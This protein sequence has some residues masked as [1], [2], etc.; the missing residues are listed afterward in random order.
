[1]GKVTSE[2]FAELLLRSA[3][4]AAEVAQGE[5]EPARTSRH[6]ITSRE[7]AVRQPPRFGAER[8]VGLREKLGVSQTVFAGM[9]GVQP[10]TV[11]AWEQEQ[12]EPA[13]AARRLLEI[14]EQR[15]AL[16]RATLERPESP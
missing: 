7:V 4:Q 12:K 3:R 11:R 16:A 6:K 15:P 14:F 2:N 10:P 1:M 5:S 13:G 8:I 9:L